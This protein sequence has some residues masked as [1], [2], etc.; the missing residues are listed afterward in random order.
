MFAYEVAGYLKSEKGCELYNGAYQLEIDKKSLSANTRKMMKLSETKKLNEEV[1]QEY[2][3]I[4]STSSSASSSAHVGAFSAGPSLSRSFANIDNVGTASD[5]CSG[6]GDTTL[7]DSCSG[8]SDTTAS[9]SCS[10]HGDYTANNTISFESSH[11]M[12]A[13]ATETSTPSSDRGA[14]AKVTKCLRA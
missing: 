7:S 3:S 8:H 1:H 4:A 14:T 10:G 6:H 2:T 13:A 5:S 9:D 11:E 12:A